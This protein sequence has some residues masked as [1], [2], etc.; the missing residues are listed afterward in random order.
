MNIDIRILNSRAKLEKMIIKKV[1]YN[2]IL[3][4]SRKLDNLINIKMNIKHG[5]SK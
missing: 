3:K 2:R 1:S 5:V 4:Q